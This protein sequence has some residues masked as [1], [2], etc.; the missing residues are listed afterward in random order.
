MKNQQMVT[1]HQ[2]KMKQMKEMPK[3]KPS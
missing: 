2:L 3:G 1:Q